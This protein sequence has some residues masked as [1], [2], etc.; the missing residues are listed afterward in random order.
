M[1]LFVLTG[2]FYLDR[3]PVATDAREPFNQRK[4]PAIFR[5]LSSEHPT[6][7]TVFLMQQPH[8]RAGD[9]V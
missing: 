4:R 1:I 8:E 3:S 5:E 2:K 7:E 9:A 6:R